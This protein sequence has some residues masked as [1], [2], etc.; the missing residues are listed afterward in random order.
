VQPDRLSV[1]LEGESVALIGL[2][3]YADAKFDLGSSDDVIRTSREPIAIKWESTGTGLR[4]TID[5]A[6]MRGYDAVEVVV[7]VLKPDALG[8]APMRVG[9]QDKLKNSHPTLRVHELVEV[10]MNVD[11]VPVARASQIPDVPI[12]CGMSWVSR[13]FPAQPRRATIEIASQVDQPHVLRATAY[14]M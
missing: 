3:R 8:N 13:T 14:G 9:R 7:E 6:S 2:G 4:A 10:A 11:G 12:F 5:P 1:Q